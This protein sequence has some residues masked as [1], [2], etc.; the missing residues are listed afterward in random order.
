MFLILDKSCCIYTKT[1]NFS[2]FFGFLITWWDIGDLFKRE[3]EKDQPHA[4][5]YTILEVYNYFSIHSLG[6]KDGGH[7]TRSLT[8]CV[9]TSRSSWLGRTR[10]KWNMKYRL[11]SRPEGEPVRQSMSLWVSVKTTTPTTARIK[12]Y[13]TVNGII[14]YCT[15]KRIVIEFWSNIIYVC[16]YN[17]KTI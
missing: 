4:L 5:R 15:I 14:Y 12:R 2:I 7:C 11:P 9:T 3:F 13:H 6:K 16:R 8:L 10:W 1:A 17:S